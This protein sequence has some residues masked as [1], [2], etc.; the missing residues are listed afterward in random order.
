M[1]VNI[2]LAN[3]DGINSEG[4]RS[5]CNFASQIGDVTIVAPKR[6][7][8]GKSHSIDIHNKFEVKKIEYKG[9]KRAFFVDSTPADCVRFAHEILGHFDMIFSGV[10]RGLNVGDDISYSGTCGAVFEGFF[11]RTPSVAF[12]VTPT[13]FTPFDKNIETIWEFFLKHELLKKNLLWNVNIPEEV[14]GIKITQQGGPYYQDYFKTDDGIMYYEVG[15]SVY[16]GSDEK[17]Y[18]DTDAVLRDNYISITPL[19]GKKT[20]SKVFE[21]LKSLNMQ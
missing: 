10:N 2:L 1:D 12:S 17:L 6:E 3:D 7:Q 11:T 18:Y 21:T 20:E 13:S 16:T 15:H 14:K 9:A 19:A 4:L 8:S 5:L